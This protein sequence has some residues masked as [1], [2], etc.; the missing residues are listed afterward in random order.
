M[1]PTRMQRLHATL[2]LRGTDSHHLAQSLG[3]A[4]T[5]LA[6]V[7]TGTRN[8]SPSLATRLAAALGTD[9]P[10]VFGIVDQLH[11]LPLRDPNGR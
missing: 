10:F 11:A 3:I 5:H 2:R 8:A 7:V 9:L 4:G 1:H 6:A